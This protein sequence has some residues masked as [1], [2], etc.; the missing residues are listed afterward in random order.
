MTAAH[1][2]VELPDFRYI[3]VL[4]MFLVVG[5]NIV[6]RPGRFSSLTDFRFFQRL[7]VVTPTSNFRATFFIPCPSPNSV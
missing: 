3:R 2:R 6:G 4:I 5:D 1:F 7:T